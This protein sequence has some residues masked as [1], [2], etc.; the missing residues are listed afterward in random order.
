MLRRTVV[1]SSGRAQQGT[2]DQSV[3]AV[4]GLYDAANSARQQ[5]R[6]KDDSVA[7]VST[8]SAE[9][10]KDAT[11]AEL[12]GSKQRE[13]ALRRE[14]RKGHQR[15]FSYDFNLAHRRDPSWRKG[16]ER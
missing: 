7:N 14:W 1:S 8:C 6:A 9:T 15:S 11:L 13:F 10:E 5:A 4:S 12:L 3:Y 16:H 2:A